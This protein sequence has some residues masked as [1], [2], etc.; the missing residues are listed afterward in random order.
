MSNQPRFDE[1]TSE[2]LNYY[3]YRLIDP[4]DGHTFY[5]GKGQGNRVFDH[6]S[7][8]KPEVTSDNL[9]RIDEDEEDLKLEI[10]RG[11]QL[12]NLEVIHVIHRHGMD[13]DTAL[14]VEAALID[15]YPGLANKAGGHGSADRGPMNT[16][17]LIDLYNRKV[18]DFGK[19]KVVVIKNRISRVEEVGLYD[20]CRWC[21]RANINRARQ[22]DYVVC[23]IAGVIKGIWKP[24]QW[25]RF[26]PRAR[27][28]ISGYEQLGKPIAN[29]I[30][31]IA[32]DPDGVKDPIITERYINHRLPD[33]MQVRGA[34][35]PVRYVNL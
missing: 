18:V 2:K 16:N 3:V 9:D 24:K 33:D 26:K 11:V 19:D 29:R 32:E 5:V 12:A 23:A 8:A 6:A 30:A 4:R 10:I 13:S 25:D 35:G 22:A 28:L 14:E 21:W 1:K 20:A 17:E 34:A 15:A 7:G 31:F 27:K